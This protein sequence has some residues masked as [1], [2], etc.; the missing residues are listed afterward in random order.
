M[1]SFYDSTRVQA[2]S[3]R[4]SLALR[5]DHYFAVGPQRFDNVRGTKRRLPHNIDV[6][7]ASHL[8]LTLSG[9][10]DRIKVFADQVHQSAL[11]SYLV[12]YFKLA[13]RM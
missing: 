13:S 5:S 9:S 6:L 8:L 11:A 3:D 12:Q 7:S 2:R 4:F 10:V 1:P